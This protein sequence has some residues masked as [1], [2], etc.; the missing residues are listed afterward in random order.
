[1]KTLTLALLAGTMLAGAATAQD[2]KVFISSQHH[3]DVWREVFDKYQQEHPG[4]SIEIQTG[5][6]TSEMQAQYLN[7]QM[8]AKDPTL[9]VVILDIIRPAQF[10]AAGWTK[11][12]NDSVENADTFMDQYLPAYGEANVVDGNIVALPA[13]A[14][15]MFLYYRADLL[16]KYN[17]QPPKTWAELEAAAK[18]I[19]E[20]EGGNLQ[21]ISFQGKA[22][23]G[24]VCTF[25]LPYWS[26]GHNLVDA[27]GK[28]N[29]DRDAA[30]KSLAM[31]KA[32]ADNGTAKPNIAEVATDDTR[33]EFQA[34]DVV[35]AVNWS[36]AWNHFQTGEDTQVK[37][38][39][40]VA[41]I[42]AV[43]G[44][45]PAT[46]LGGWQWGVSAY[47]DQAEAAT[48]LVKYLSSPEVAEYMAVN[49]SLMPIFPEVYTDPEVTAAVPWFETALPVVETARA[50]PVTP[51][52]NEVSEI[53]RTTVNAVL[54]GTVTPEEGAD[55][56]EARLRRVLR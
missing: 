49:A 41:T 48:E 21:G 4:V 24:A 32:M 25:L 26:M 20:G 5:G 14:D 10:A 35:F 34:G 1:M 18:T 13:F 2:L 36:Y 44:G 6:N 53:V 37:D 45:E 38:K 54:A 42:P 15:A 28:L 55:Q 7:T 39:V 46:C 47:S 22:I 52:Y 16:E 43:E 9:D 40:G 11:P 50:R 17:L 27:D 3:P 30:V 8:S 12:L 56:M 23:E 19:V 51:R 33:K 31:W 29:F